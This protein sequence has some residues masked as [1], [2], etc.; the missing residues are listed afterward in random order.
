M[1]AMTDVAIIGVD[2][3]R[4][5]F[6]LHGA[7]RDGTVAFRKKLTRTQ[8]E[9]FMASHPVATVAFEACGG[10]HH[11]ARELVGMGHEVRLIAA[12]YV[13]P[14]VKRQKNDA[15]DAE[16][17]VEAALRPTMRFV[18][19]K[20][21]GQQAS[22]VLFRHRERLVKQRTE[23]INAVRAFLC[24]F[25]HVIPKGP[26]H[27]RRAAEIVADDATAVP[28]GVRHVCREMLDEID[29][30]TV[31]IDAA[32]KRLDA[33]ARQQDTARRLQTVPGIGPIAAAAIE[34]F[35]PPI[36]TFRKGRDFAAWLGLVPRQSSTGGKQR[37][38][39]TSKMGQ[40]DVRRLLIVGAMSMVNWASRGRGRMTPWLAA[41]LVRKPRMLVAVALANKMARTIWAMSVRQ[42]DY[43]DP[44]R[45]GA[46]A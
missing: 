17:I 7:A 24:E 11:W 13:R 9:K 1:A 41:M 31:Q 42:E 44:M 4:N 19:P 26:R 21:E 43:C 3:V 40:R 16:A 5:V 37:L 39:R 30:K 20:T 29:R 23:L 46:A 15:A 6:H 34:T 2:L 25:G 45:T 12:Q 32:R 27:L 10:A 38:G 8:F 35:A 22:A 14:F 36:E 33:L 28:E 18:A